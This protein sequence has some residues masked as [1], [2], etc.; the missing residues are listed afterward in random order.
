[1]QPEYFILKNFKFESKYLLPQ[2]KIEYASFGKKEI[3]ENGRLTNAIIYLHGWSGDYTSIKRIKD[4]VGPGKPINTDKYYVICPTALG[5]PGSSSPST[6]GLGY[7][8][9]EYTIKDMVNAVHSFLKECF[10]ITHLKGIIG[11]SAGGFQ[12][13][14]WAVSYPDFMDFVIPITTSHEVKGKNFAIFNLMNT[15]I[16]EDPEYNEGE[17]EQNP[18][19]GCQ[20]VSMLQ[21]LFVFSNQYYKNNSNEEIIQSLNE[22]KKEALKMDA[23]DIVWRNEAV[24]AYSITSRISQIKSKMLIIAINQDEYFPPETETIPLSKLIEGSKLFLYDSILGHLG[25]SEI[26]KAE[27]VIKEFLEDL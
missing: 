3:D 13:L 10:N 11:M 9:P 1:M 20:N 26:K 17:Y 2:L 15:F 14:E 23:N 19:M 16:K 27:N 25:S 24:M 6:S 7:D 22:M 4:I 5:S 8:F 12:A 18:E 21:Y